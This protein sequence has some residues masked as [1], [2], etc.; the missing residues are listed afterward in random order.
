MQEFADHKTVQFINKQV[1]E[2]AISWGGKTS[3]CSFTTRSPLYELYYFP[4][5]IILIPIFFFW[6]TSGGRSWV[7]MMGRGWGRG[8]EPWLP[9]WI[10]TLL[11]LR[12]R[13]GSLNFPFFNQLLLLVVLNLAHPLLENEVV[14]TVF[15]W[16]GPFDISHFTFYKIGWNCF[17]FRKGG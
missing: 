3:A 10:A 4:W 8:I 9:V 16:T 2:D 11:P 5:W 12:L 13:P 6:D 1:E 14:R 7:S 17:R 15:T